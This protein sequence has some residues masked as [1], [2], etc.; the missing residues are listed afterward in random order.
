MLSTHIDVLYLVEVNSR[1]RKTEEQQRAKKKRTLYAQLFTL[2]FLYSVCASHSLSS[3]LLL[4]RLL[5]WNICYFRWTISVIVLP[6]T[7][8]VLLKTDVLCSLQIHQQQTASPCLGCMVIIS[9][10][11]KRRNKLPHTTQHRSTLATILIL[12]VFIVFFIFFNVLLYFCC[13]S[14]MKGV[15]SVRSANDVEIGVCVCWD[16]VRI[17]DGAD[18]YSP[19]IAMV[20]SQPRNVATDNA[21][22][23]I[24][25]DLSVEMIYIE[26][27]W[28]VRTAWRRC[29]DRLNRCNPSIMHQPDRSLTCCRSSSTAHTHTTDFMNYL[30]LTVH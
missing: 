18:W 17:D 24:I 5:L 4:L 3:Q 13:I 25:F 16:R 19:Y 28:L 8:G 11:E 20:L 21:K 30:I 10:W 12:F 29:I 6:F 23:V 27:C 22:H 2:F 9:A 7:V 1:N 14:A 15:K 26:W